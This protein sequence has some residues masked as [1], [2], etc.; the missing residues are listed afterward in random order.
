MEGV[1]SPEKIIPLD[2]TGIL[3]IKMN[4]SKMEASEKTRN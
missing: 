4:T 3:L 2:E 1:P